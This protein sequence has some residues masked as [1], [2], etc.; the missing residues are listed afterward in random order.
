MPDQGRVALVSGGDE[1]LGPEIVRRL[2]ALGM[3]VVLGCRS[4]ERGRLLIDDLGELADQV[5]VRPL[6]VTEVRSVEGLA[7][8][9]TGRLGRCDVLVSNVVLRS[10]EGRQSNGSLEEA[11]AELSANIDGMRR[12][13]HVLAP[14][15]RAT[16]YGRV[17]VIVSDDPITATVETTMHRTACRAVTALITELAEDLVGGGILANA[18]CRSPESGVGAPGSA[19]ETP[20]WLA[21]LPA[22]GPTGRLYR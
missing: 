15:M 12:L 18:Y 20:V 10:D 6:D 7:S 14:M 1:G 13:T 11:R 16:G 17:V 5:A 2:S 4:V 3:R 8:W 22:D 19:A 21:T 9:V